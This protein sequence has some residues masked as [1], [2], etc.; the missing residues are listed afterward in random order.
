VRR[1]GWFLGIA[2][3]G[4]T[5]LL[6]WRAAGSSSSAR[7][8]R[9]AGV[10]FDAATGLRAANTSAPRTNDSSDSESAVPTTGPGHLVALRGGIAALRGAAEQ[11]EGLE[12]AARLAE[13]KGTEEQRRKLAAQLA[14]LR[15]E[16]AALAEARRRARAELRRWLVEDA[17]HPLELYLLLRQSEYATGLG[18]AGRLLAGHFD[19]A[20]LEAAVLKDLRS[21]PD[22]AVR[23]LALDVVS[24]RASQPRLA[25]ATR[26]S[27]ADRSAAV[28]ERAVGVLHGYQGDRRMIA[29]RRQI[30]A[31]LLAAAGDEDPQVR[32]RALVALAGAPQ[33]N[34]DMAVVFQNLQANDPDRSV[35]TVA[36]QALRRW[37]APSGRS[38]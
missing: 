11:V 34:K 16:E 20:R 28:R 25:E 38:E 4:V 27:A 17:G 35:R 18:R 32:V 37:S 31:T 14:E 6:V 23:L 8:E 1:T 36:K 12:E 29:Q 9:T 24:A 26:L 13:A 2:V 19:N 15:Q 10:S 5:C 3:V 33:P 21:S 7:T 30:N 22:E